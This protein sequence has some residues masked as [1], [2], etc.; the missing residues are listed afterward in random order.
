MAYYLH[1]TYP[2]GTVLTLAS[3]TRLLRA[4][5]IISL[6]DKPVTLRPEDREVA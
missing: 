5:W 4:L 2:N 6:A 3:A 1:V